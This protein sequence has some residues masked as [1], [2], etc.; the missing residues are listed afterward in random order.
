M[1]FPGGSSDKKNLGLPMQET[2]ETEVQSLG[3]EDPLQEGMAP[4]S[5]ILA[6]SVQ[7]TEEPDGLQSMGLQRVRQDWSDLARTQ[8]GFMYLP[9][10][11]TILTREWEINDLTKGLD[12]QNL[13]CQDPWSKERIRGQR[14]KEEKWAASWT[15]IYKTAV[16]Q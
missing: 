12:R 7:R 5:S 9:R 15:R 1:D 8:M 3:W 14:K 2:Y 4:H 11:R 13:N 6:W 10:T 16:R